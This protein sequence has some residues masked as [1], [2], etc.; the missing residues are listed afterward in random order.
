MIFIEEHLSNEMLVRQVFV[1]E[2]DM[3]DVAKSFE[4]TRGFNAI[5]K[6]L[7]QNLISLEVAILKLHR[8]INQ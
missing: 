1:A 6:K 5:R 3:G 8:V 2:V 7:I 4:C